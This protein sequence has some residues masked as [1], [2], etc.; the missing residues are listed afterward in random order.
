MNA[1][2]IQTFTDE[3]KNQLV[4]VPE[5]FF[6]F[7]RLNFGIGCILHGDE[8]TENVLASILSDK[9]SGSIYRLYFTQGRNRSF[10]LF[11]DNKPY[12]IGQEVKHLTSK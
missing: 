7:I 2:L 12:G 8:P 4:M 1:A 11:V 10:C 3:P 5:N 6:D 9:H